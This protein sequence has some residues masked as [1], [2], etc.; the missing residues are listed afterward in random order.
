MI[1]ITYPT[2]NRKVDDWKSQLESL[3][4]SH[5]LVED[6]SFEMPILKDSSETVK[7][8]V[9]IDKYMNSLME[10]QEVW[11]ACSCN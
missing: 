10:F 5:Q 2:F 11:F 8:E 1:T 3:V 6:A 7:G 9:A 4:T